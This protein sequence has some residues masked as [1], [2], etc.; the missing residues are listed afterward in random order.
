MD[1]LQVCGHETISTERQNFRFHF[2]IL[3]ISKT[4]VP[5][6]MPVLDSAAQLG[7]GGREAGL[8]HLQGYIS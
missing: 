6:I 3:D 1:Y 4:F 8:H 5:S 2:E 7:A